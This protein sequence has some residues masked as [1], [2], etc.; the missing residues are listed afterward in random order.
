MTEKYIF[1]Q[2]IL[3]VE[4]RFTSDYANGSYDENK[5]YKPALVSTGWWLIFED[6]T[7]FRMGEKPEELKRGDRMKFV[8]EKSQ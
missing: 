4:E 8:M 7:A 5:N 1:Y 2:R 6:N 3:D